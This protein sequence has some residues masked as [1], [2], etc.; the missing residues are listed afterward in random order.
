MIQRVLNWL[1]SLQY[2]Y[3]DPVQRQRARALLTMTWAGVLIW[4]LIYVFVIIPLVNSGEIPGNGFMFLGMTATPVALAIIFITVQQGR[5]ILSSALLVGGLLGLTVP[6]GLVSHIDLMQLMPIIA[7]VAAGVLLNRRG[8]AVVTLIAIGSM[9]A[10]AFYQSNLTQVERFVPA[11]LVVNEAITMIGIVLLIAAFLFAFSGTPERVAREASRTANQWRAISILTDRM[12]INEESAI[13]SVLRLA[14]EG[15]HYDVAQVFI[16]NERVGVARRY[17]LIETGTV[18]SLDVTPGIVPETVLRNFEPLIIRTGDTRAQDHLVNP[19]KV[20][21]TV[22]VLFEGTSL[23]VLDVQLNSY[24]PPDET[25]IAV[26][27][28]LA[29]QL[30]RTLA[31]TRRISALEFDVRDQEAGTQ[32]L[33]SQLAELQRRAEGTTTAGWE[34]YLRGLGVTGYGYDLDA[35]AR[36]LIPASDLPPAVRETLERGDVHIERQGSKQTISA[37]IAYRNQML[38]AM[39]F[40]V[41]ADKM[42]GDA[43]LELVRTVSNRLGIAL[44]NN[45]LFEQSQA[46]ALRERKASEVGGLL[47][48]ATDIEQVLTLAAETFNEALGATHTRVSLQPGSLT[49]LETEGR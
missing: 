33:R 11:D 39:T 4:V 6:L 19:A 20:S 7:L 17:R 25:R 36:G 27:K 48:T 31:Q 5:L 21:V 40:I 37:P 24:D 43:E 22:P 16:L 10:T 30:A 32:R 44:E 3:I 8:L 2:D 47:L 46:Q 9:I 1:F 15:L 45:R 26:V 41:P 28:G 14:R 35:S 23:G 38:G 18:M 12:F 42:L 49:S 29:A 34:R 13:D